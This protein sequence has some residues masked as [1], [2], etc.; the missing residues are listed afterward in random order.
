MM[1]EFNAQYIANLINR[2]F[3]A[4]TYSLKAL[5]WTIEA[6]KITLYRPLNIPLYKPPNENRYKPELPD[7]KDLPEDIRFGI[8]IQKCLLV[9][10]ANGKTLTT[11][12]M[13]ERILNVERK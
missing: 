5:D 3:E 4:P 8:L 9:A 7:F 2:A 11:L 10:R 6:S 13:I 12:K 1:E